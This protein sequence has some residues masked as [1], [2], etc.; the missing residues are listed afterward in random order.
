MSV[1][2]VI[3]LLVALCSCS[4]VKLQSVYEWSVGDD[5]PQGTSSL[6]HY[7]WR[8]VEVRIIDHTAHR[9]LLPLPNSW[10]VP[11]SQYVSLP[12][13]VSLTTV[14]YRI[15]IVNQAIQTLLHGSVIPDHIYLFVSDSPYLMDRGVTD[16]PENL[17]IFVANKQLSVIFTDNIG[18]HRK[19]LPLLSKHYQDDV[20]I[21]TVDDDMVYYPN[22]TMVETLLQGYVHTQGNA[23]VALRS[24]RIGFCNA[25]PHAFL[26]Y[27]QWS[28]FDADKA[29]TEMLLVP[30]GT[31]G[32]LYRPRFFPTLV[33]SPDLR[34]I[35]STSDDLMFRLCTMTNHVPVR[36]QCRPV[37]EEGHVVRRCLDTVGR[38]LT[39]LE[40]QVESAGMNDTTSIYIPNYARKEKR[41]LGGKTLYKG[42]RRGMNDLSWAA[43]V[44]YLASNNILEFQQLVDTYYLERETECYQQH[45]LGGKQTKH[46]AVADCQGLGKKFMMAI[47]DIK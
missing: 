26:K 11:L 36:T 22:N 45:K 34:N 30:T 23:V 39:N 27:T 19:L 5:L 13:Y 6:E 47:E 38:E 46:C 21:M 17:L 7:Q 29:R 18:P 3:L 41:S 14:S 40:Q 42:N 44:Q 43:A 1:T 12:V 24:R 8:K 9:E 20:I 35:T 32:V 33:F 16:L 4:L 10:A 2:P 28:I 25:Y 37:I 31:G 15:H